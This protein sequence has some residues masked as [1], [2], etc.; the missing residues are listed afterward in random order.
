M[1]IDDEVLLQEFHNAP[2][3]FEHQQAYPYSA[4]TDFQAKC[5]VYERPH[6][7]YSVLGPQSTGPVA[8]S[9]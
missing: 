1:P 7:E 9:D 8:Q 3:L 2:G 6:H 5:R 4:V